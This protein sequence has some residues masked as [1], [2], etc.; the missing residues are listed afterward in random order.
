MIGGLGRC[1]AGDF[2]DA[3]DLADSG[4]ARPSMVL[5][6]HAMSVE[7]VAVRVSGE[8]WEKFLRKRIW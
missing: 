5:I 1:V 4:Q 3:F 6:S 8:N 7:T 2:A